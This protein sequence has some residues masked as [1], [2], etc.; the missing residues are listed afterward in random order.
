MD[1]VLAAFPAP[2]IFESATAQEIHRVLR[3]GGKAVFLLAFRPTS[4]HL[5]DRVIRILFRFTGQEPPERINP[6]M[7]DQAYLEAGFC[8]Q[9]L[10]YNKPGGEMLVIEA[11]TTTRKS[12]LSC[13]KSCHGNSDRGI[14]D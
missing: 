6:G 5:A 7:L 11:K 12:T 13:V 3:P 10:W 1:G 8:V 9:T 4:S 14:Q 2:F